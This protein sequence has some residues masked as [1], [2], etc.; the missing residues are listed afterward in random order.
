MYGGAAVTKAP[1]TLLSTSFLFYNYSFINL[2]AIEN[3]KRAYRINCQLIDSS[4][5]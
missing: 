4:D 1:L 2:Y 5:S 3:K